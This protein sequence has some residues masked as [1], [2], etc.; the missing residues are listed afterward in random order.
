MENGS[1]APVCAKQMRAKLEGC[2]NLIFIEEAVKIR[3]A[4][5]A[6]SAAMIDKLAEELAKN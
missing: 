2:K 5:N 1:W 3:A 4:L 6:E